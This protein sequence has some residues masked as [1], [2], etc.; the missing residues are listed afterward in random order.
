MDQMEIRIG[1]RNQSVIVTLAG[2]FVGK[3]AGLIFLEV[4]SALEKT[5]A[6]R[7]I[8]DMAGLEYLGSQGISALLAI[9]MAHPSRFVGVSS[10]M[11]VLLERA[12]LKGQLQCFGTVEEAEKSF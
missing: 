12:G 7:I 9:S 8:F 1:S 3:D 2:K 6:A 5:K 10:E 4:T 11:Q